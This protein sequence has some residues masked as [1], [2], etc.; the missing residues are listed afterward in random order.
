MVPLFLSFILFLILGCFSISS[1]KAGFNLTSGICLGACF[2]FACRWFGFSPST[3]GTREN[4]D[5]L[6]FCDS[7]PVFLFRLLQMEQSKTIVDSL[8]WTNGSVATVRTVE[9]NSF[10]KKIICSFLFLFICFRPLLIPATYFLFWLEWRWFN[11][12]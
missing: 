12:P 2:L 1:N 5:Y 4:F 8:P 11:L 7:F 3:L 10:D 9:I 6:E